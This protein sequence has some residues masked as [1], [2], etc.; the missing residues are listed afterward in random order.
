MSARGAIRE[1]DDLAR[2]R[3]FARQLTTRPDNAPK[4]TYG[5]WV[6]RKRMGRE[7]LLVVGDEPLPWERWE[8]WKF[9]RMRP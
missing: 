7:L 8:L 1:P 5:E 9:E 6:E 3:A 4:L 2:I